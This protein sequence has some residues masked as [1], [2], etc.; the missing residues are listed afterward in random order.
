MTSAIITT[1]CKQH[2]DT[3]DKVF[4]LLSMKQLKIEGELVCL[5]VMVLYIM[6]SVIG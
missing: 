1:I 3:A 2:Y 6:Y 4:S 5:F